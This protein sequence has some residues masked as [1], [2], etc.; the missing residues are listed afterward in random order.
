LNG[1]ELAKAVANSLAILDWKH[2]TSQVARRIWGAVRKID[3]VLTHPQTRKTLGI[4]CKFQAVL[5]TAEEKIPAT[6]KDIDAWPI[7]GLVVFE[8]EALP[9]I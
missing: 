8:G 7:P 2:G 4:E 6:I 1:D 5:G 9:R 3:V